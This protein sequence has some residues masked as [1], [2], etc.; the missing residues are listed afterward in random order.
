MKTKLFFAI[1]ILISSISTGQQKDNSSIIKVLSFNIY[2]GENMLEKSNLDDIVTLINKLQPDF[3]GLQEVDMNTERSNY[4]NISTFL[5]YKTNMHPIFAKAMDFNHGEY[6]VALLSKKSF[7]NTERYALPTKK[8]REPRVLIAVNTEIHRQ[9]IQVIN[10]H[11]DHKK[12]EGLR[13]KQANFVNQLF[14]NDELPKI[15]IGDLNALPNSKTILSLEKKWMLSDNQAVP[16]ATYPWDNPS[17]KIDYIM[18]Y[19]KNKWRVLES[20]VINTGEISDHLAYFV[21]L[22]LL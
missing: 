2:H 10:T 3:V 6:G 15:L 20:T 12:K 1:L 13:K 22:E 4:K 5:G 18:M 17:K 19:P 16:N 21:T 14:C 8:H 7:K 11:F 9:E